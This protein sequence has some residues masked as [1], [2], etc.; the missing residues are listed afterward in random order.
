[1]ETEPRPL[2]SK[3]NPEKNVGWG[4]GLGSCF[5]CDAFQAATRERNKAQICFTFL[6]ETACFY[7]PDGRGRLRV[8]GFPNECDGSVERKINQRLPKK[9]K[10]K[11]VRTRKRGQRRAAA[12]QGFGFKLKSSLKTEFQTVPSFNS[13]TKPANLALPTYFWHQSGRE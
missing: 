4:L 3:S 6:G 10:K 12:G 9:K 8:L 7:G 13:E 2:T 1:M 11:T 5:C